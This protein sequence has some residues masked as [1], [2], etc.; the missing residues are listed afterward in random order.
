[1]LA[2][3]PKIIEEKEEDLVEESISD[4]CSDEKLKHYKNIL[5]DMKVN[6]NELF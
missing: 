1:M 5:L 4:D 6:N 3:L 2:S